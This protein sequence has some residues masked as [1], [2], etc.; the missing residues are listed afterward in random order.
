[1]NAIIC[2]TKNLDREVSELH[3]WPPLQQDLIEALFS[4][5]DDAFQLL[6]EFNRKPKQFM[7]IYSS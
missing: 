2:K 3:N 5:R 6:L 7:F 4:S 1:M